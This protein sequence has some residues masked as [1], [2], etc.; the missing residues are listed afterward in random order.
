MEGLEKAGNPNALQL[1]IMA[2]PG[3]GKSLLSRTLSILLGIP[4]VNQVC[5]AAFKPDTAPSSS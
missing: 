5:I 3:C 2:V 4:W 1:V